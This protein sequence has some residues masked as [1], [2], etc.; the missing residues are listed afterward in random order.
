[1]KFKTELVLKFKVQ[2]ICSLRHFGKHWFNIYFLTI[3]IRIEITY[4][5]DVIKKSSII[6]RIAR[7]LES[8]WIIKPIPQSTLKVPNGNVTLYNIAFFIR[9]RNRFRASNTVSDKRNNLY[10]ITYISVSINFRYVVV[11]MKF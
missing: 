8:P 1:M 6:N 4:G 7:H 2:I 5:N 3:R 11:F 9:F 10:N